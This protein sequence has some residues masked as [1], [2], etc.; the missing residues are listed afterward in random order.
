MQM[1]GWVCTH[2]QG[3]V[4]ACVHT[5]VLVFYEWPDQHLLQTGRV[6]N[7]NRMD[8]PLLEGPLRLTWHPPHKPTNGASVVRWLQGV[9]RAKSSPSS[10]QKGHWVPWAC[11]VYV[12]AS[13]A[14]LPPAAKKGGGARLPACLPAC[15][16]ASPRSPHH[17]L[18][19]AQHVWRASQPLAHSPCGAHVPAGEAEEQPLNKSGMSP[20]MMAKL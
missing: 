9:L 12:F 2:A 4:C 8:Q 20:A 15:P 13:P 18:V 17:L 10:K 7:S 16:F 1:S 3:S 6:R 14:L 5:C 11:F 19:Q